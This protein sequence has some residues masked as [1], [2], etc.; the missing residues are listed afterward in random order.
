MRKEGIDWARKAEEDFMPSDPRWDADLVIINHGSGGFQIAKDREEKSPHHRVD[1]TAILS[2]L[3]RAGPS[4][5][6][7][8]MNAEEMRENII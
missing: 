4:V 8:W 2:R 1:W 7:Y 5:K 6:V 3:M